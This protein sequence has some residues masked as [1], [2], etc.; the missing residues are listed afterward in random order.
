[1]V[2]LY[3]GLVGVAAGLLAHAFLR[4]RGEQGYNIIGEVMLGA[5]GSL[6]LAMSVGVLLGWGQMFVRENV[7]W[8]EIVVSGVTALIGGGAVLVVVVY[9]TLRSSP[10]R[11]PTRR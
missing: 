3:W 10:I 7:R 5:T 11:Q 2:L 4:I 6:S 8:D 1:M 9:L